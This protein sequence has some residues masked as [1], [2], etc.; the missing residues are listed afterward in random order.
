LSVVVEVS[1][2]EYGHELV[3]GMVSKTDIRF[4]IVPIDQTSPCGYKFSKEIAKISWWE[5]FSALLRRKMLQ[6]YRDRVKTV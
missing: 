2:G 4:P 5:Q 6:F 3:D 1:S